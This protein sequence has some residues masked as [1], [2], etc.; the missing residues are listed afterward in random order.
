M[1]QDYK[2][3]SGPWYNPENL[4]INTENCTD[5]NQND[6]NYAKN[7]NQAGSKKNNGDNLLSETE[8][9]ALVFGAISMVLGIF[10]LLG[11]KLVFGILGLVF[12][13][14]SNGKKQN[15]YAKIG[16]ICSIISLAIAA[17]TLI[18]ILALCAIYGTVVLE[19]LKDTTRI[20]V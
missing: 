1:I 11:E 13:K 2:N 17:V 16:I 5:E 8:D 12:G 3:D 9:N 15:T 14:I 18:V 4:N 20:N 6:Q 19:V 10:S 7:E